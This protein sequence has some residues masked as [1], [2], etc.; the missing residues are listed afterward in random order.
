MNSSNLITIE[1]I[2]LLKKWWHAF[3]NYTNACGVEN[4]NAFNP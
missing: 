3:R 1:K 4:L 2:Q